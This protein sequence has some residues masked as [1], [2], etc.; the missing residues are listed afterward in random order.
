MHITPP[1]RFRLRL[2]A[3]LPGKLPFTK[4]EVQVEVSEGL[5]FEI[6]ARNAE[7][8][9]VATNFHVDGTGFESAEAA[10]LA[11]EALRVRLRLLNAILGLGL[12]VP[13][14]NKVSAQV[15]EEIKNKLKSEQGATII[16]SVWGA[17]VF[18]DDGHHFE[19]VVSG[20][21][22]VSPSDPEYLLEGI[23]K[24]WNL[25]ISLDKQSEDALQI[26]CLATHRRLPT[27]QHSSQVTLRWRNS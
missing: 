15:S 16:D 23:K 20:N 27:R 9:D 13:V 8:L 10:T 4:P 22:V 11:A 2:A 14:G 25:D 18:P 5:T 19:Y 17:S 3:R 12:N 6:A 26:L 21:V 1:F 24:L 7:T